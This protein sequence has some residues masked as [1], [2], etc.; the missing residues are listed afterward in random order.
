[1]VIYSIGCSHT[2]GH[3]LENK[4]LVWSNIIMSSFSKNYTT[5]GVNFNKLDVVSLKNSNDVFINDSICG[6]GNDFIYHKTLE[7]VSLLIKEN[8]KPDYVF[9]QWSGPNRRQHCTPD[10]NIIYVNL[11]DNVGEGIKFEP[12]ASLHTLHYMFSLQEFLKNNNIKYHFFNYFGLDHS[13]KDTN[14]FNNI[15]FDFFLDFNLGDNFLY[16]G[17]LNFMVKNNYSCDEHGHPNI[18]GNY[19]IANHILN[20]IKDNEFNS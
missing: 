15:N 4:D 1:M 12:M 3:C 18:E 9:I 13:I 6:A 8:K 20:K 7:S 5:Y 10:G 17:L 16:E 14:V 19:F 11:F 2:Y